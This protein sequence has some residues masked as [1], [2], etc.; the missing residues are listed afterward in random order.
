MSITEVLV[1]KEEKDK[2]LH[3]FILQCRSKPAV[4]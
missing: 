1:L 4:L 3:Q 2:N